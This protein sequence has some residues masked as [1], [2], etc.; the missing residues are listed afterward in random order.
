MFYSYSI[1]AQEKQNS[2]LAGKG[3]LNLEKLKRHSQ[4][5]C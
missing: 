5:G 1:I 2:S 3:E 4:V